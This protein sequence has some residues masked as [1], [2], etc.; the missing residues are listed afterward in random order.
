MDDQT[1]SDLAS[2]LVDKELS[3]VPGQKTDSAKIITLIKQHGIEI[4][5]NQFQEPYITSLESNFIA[6]PIKSNKTKQLI[7]KLFWD[8][9]KKPPSNKAIDE[10]INTLGGLALYENSKIKHVYNRIG[11]I[12][13]EIYYD[14]GDNQNVVKITG[15]GWSIEQ[16]CPLIFRRFGHQDKQVL[17][18]KGGNLKTI[19][20][21]VNISD[22]NNQILLLTHIVTCFVPNIPRSA[23]AL[24]GPPGSAKSTLLKMM[25]LLIDPSK[26]PLVTH[27]PDFKELIQTASHQYVVFL[28]NLSR[29]PEKLS[30]TLCRF[31]TGDSF[32]KRELY[33]V[34]SDVLY[35]F[36]RAI[37]VCGVNLVATKSDLLSR[38]L[39]ITLDLIDRN[40]RKEEGA[41]LNKF[42]KDRPKILGAVFDC[43][44]YCLKNVPNLKLHSLPRMADHYKYSAAAAQFL[45][46]T[47]EQLETASKNNNANQNEEA[48][49]A[50]AVA[51]VVLEF[52]EELDSWDGT[53]SKL[54]SELEDIVEK[55]KLKKSFPKSPNWL[56]RRI[57]EVEI[58]LL[59][60]G[61]KVENLRDSKANSIRLSKVDSGNSAQDDR[62]VI[63]TSGSMEAMEEEI[64]F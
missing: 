14:I 53:S 24:S 23:L 40:Q 39:I 7:G 44:S 15:A 17:P 58:N 5:L 52:M 13:N 26:T 1:K 37:G 34:D 63:P 61:I 47:I 20:D 28:D 30:D 36:R 21:S 19:I 9:Y 22:K 64:P 31:V 42:K 11:R 3:K 45:G 6:Q 10:A 27:N 16:N 55:L 4:F 51:Q 60:S 57:K 41:V 54:Y 18:E 32:S 2:I 50:S 62:F 56:I 8:R 59:D 38:S 29:L 43:L 49:G 35:A 48:L 46:Y 25:R 12:K 33:T